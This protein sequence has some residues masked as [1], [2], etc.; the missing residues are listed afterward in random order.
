M[1]INMDP[2]SVHANFLRQ[3]WM[4]E[5]EEKRKRKLSR[6]GVNPNDPSTPLSNPY[7]MDPTKF[8]DLGIDTTGAENRIQQ[9][10]KMADALRGNKQDVVVDAGGPSNIKVVNP[11]NALAN[12]A[13]DG[14]SGYASGKADRREEET[15][16]TPKN[17]LAQAVAAKDAAILGRDQAN[18][19]REFGLKSD[20]LE[21]NLGEPERALAEAIA[22][23]QRKIAAENRATAARRAEAVT[24]AP[25]SLDGKVVQIVTD[26]TGNRYLGG[27]DGEPIDAKTFARAVD[28]RPGTDKGT[29]DDVSAFQMPIA[30][31]IAPERSLF[32][33]IFT[34]PYFE[35][36]TGMFDPERWA[37][38]AALGPDGKMV[39]ATQ[40]DMATA[41]LGPMAQRMEEI[42]L[43]PWTER[44]IQTITADFPDAD[45]EYPDWAR[46]GARVMI[47]KMEAKFSEAIDAGRTTPEMRDQVI[48]QMYD[49]VVEGW[50]MNSGGRDL[51][52]LERLGVPKARIK[53]YLRRKAEEEDG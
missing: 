26:A 30:E 44:E 6:M 53:A 52:D 21:F 29:L 40:S 11:F 18:K 17:R 28:Y 35:Q 42:N 37:G 24:S 8:R 10:R 48:G 31:Q 19:D 14:L 5:E 50:R 23:D 4:E 7:Q 27:L 15:V 2:R 13:I 1:A 36:S 32:G 22:A 38:K 51:K 41:T 47:P 45:S 49:E 16:D 34:S 12:I 39:Q 25:Y 33:G 43:R 46:F 3:S 20:Q 9:Q